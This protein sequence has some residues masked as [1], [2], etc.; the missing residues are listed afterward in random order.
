[1]RAEIDLRRITPPMS[2]SRYKSVGLL[3]RFAAG[4]FCSCVSLSAIA[5]TTTAPA[6]PSPGGDK[7]IELSAFE[8]EMSQS[9][10]YNATNAGSALKTG[11]RLLQIPQSVSVIT[12]DMI[13][14]VGSFSTSDTLNYSGVGN[15]YQGDSAVI[16]GVRAGM[17][18]DGA[19]DT[20][21]DNISL[22]SITVLRGPIGVLY[23]FQGTLG[24]AVIKNTK[25][26]LSKPMT[27]TNLKVDQYGYMRAEFDQSKPLGMLGKAK[28]AYRLAATHQIGNN[29]LD[30]MEA[31]RSLIFGVVEFSTPDSVLRLNAQWQALDQYPHK[32]NF[33]A[34]DGKPYVGAG[35]D[36]SFQPE[37]TQNSRYFIFR[38]QYIQRV[39]DNWGLTIRAV[40]SRQQ[41]EP[42]GVTL[43]AGG[44]NFQTGQV[45]ITARRND[46]DRQD[47]AGTLDIKGEYRVLGFKN[48]TMT[49]LLFTSL[50]NFGSFQ[51]DTSMGLRNGQTGGTFFVPMNR[52][53]VDSW[54]VL[55]AA[56]YVLPTLPAGTTTVTAASPN[57]GSTGIT[58]TW[59]EYLQQNIELW[60]DRVTLVGSIAHS[61]STSRNEIKV[62]PSAAVANRVTSHSTQSG[63]PRRVGAVFNVTK[64]V[65]VYVLNSQFFEVQLSRLIDGAFTPPRIGD[66]KEIGVKAD[67]FNGRLSATVSAFDN[68]YTNNAISAGTGVISPITGL[69]YSVLVEGTSTKGWDL[70]LFATPLPNWQTTISVT[71]S[72]VNNPANINGFGRLPF[73]FRH[74]YSFLTRYDFRTGALKPFSVGGGAWYSTG[75]VT[76][77]GTYI[78]PNG[79]NFEPGMLGADGNKSVADGGQARAFVEYRA[80]RNWTVRVDVDNLFDELTMVG[81]QAA[82]IVDVSSPRT[83]SCR[84]TYKF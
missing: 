8:V 54:N 82:F 77:S 24:G 4:A 69:P 72:K 35:R 52:P 36:E 74:F 18:T 70:S 53:N 3:I 19:A 66:G 71:N 67:L 31:N 84:A 17:M 22:D 60:P 2:T 25:T 81:S 28:V 68:K 5:Q 47:Y 45:G 63:N 26:P 14:D 57:Q 59:T 46:F 12:R 34:P 10:G 61:Y 29:Y 16:R 27:S 39:F 51:G 64:D 58:Y 23:G 73:T 6:A 48:Q 50:S 49:G 76:A 37:Q 44:L 62:V 65:A 43:A 75:R 79:Q 30:R 41:N 80:N 13:D 20:N 78:Y 7:P 42:I 38:A 33:L 55:K 40:S 1:M 21:F 32:A 83:V 56:D 11:E 15:F 9:A